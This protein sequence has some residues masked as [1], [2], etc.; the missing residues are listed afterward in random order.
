MSEA[1]QQLAFGSLP[2]MSDA[3]T[4][5]GAGVA[6]GDTVALSETAPFVTVA[7]PSEVR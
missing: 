1:E 6:S 2:L 3:Q 4:L 5:G 7:L